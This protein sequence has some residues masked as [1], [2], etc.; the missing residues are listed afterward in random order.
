MADDTDD[1]FRAMM[2][3]VFGGPKASDDWQQVFKEDEKED[4]KEDPE[5]VL[6]FL[7]LGAE[8]VGSGERKVGSSV[9]P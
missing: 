8:R 2:L 3:A 7:E 6:N 9:G 4:E 5:P 1:A